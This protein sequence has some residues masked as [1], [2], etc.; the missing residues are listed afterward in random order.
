[1]ILVEIIINTT[2]Y[3]VS[4]EGNDPDYEWTYNWKPYVISFDSPQYQ[5]ARAWGGYCQL[6]FGSI[7]LSPDLFSSE[8]PPPVSNDITI[9]YTST[10][11]DSPETFFT[12]VAHLR[13][14]TQDSIIYDLFGEKYDID[15]L[16]E[17]TDYSGNTVPLPRAFGS[18]SYVNPVR[19]ADVG[20]KP[21]YHKGYVAGTKGTDWHVFDDG[22]DIDGNVTD[23]GDGTFSLSATPVGQVSISGT[24]KYGTGVNDE[25]TSIMEWA[26]GASYLNET[27]ADTYARASQPSVAHWAGNQRKILDFLSDLCAFFTHLFYIDSSGLHLVDM[28]LD[29]G[30]SIYT[31]FEYMPSAYEYAPPVSLFSSE[32]TEREPGEWVASGGGA[33][34]AAAVYVK[35]TVMSTSKTSSY[36][37]GSEEQIEPYQATESDITTALTDIESFIHKPGCNL[38]IPLAGSLPSPGEKL[39]WTD[40]SLGQSTDIWIRARTIKYNFNDEEII[41]EG[42]GEMVATP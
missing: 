7:E 3:R 1:M 40:T 34:T 5:L 31:E 4:M 35:E 2:T 21:T 8:W 37:Y 32:W 38:K 29:N 22:V 20:G 36:A 19:L 28:K 13:S 42:E 12:G 30:S 14:I 9:K 16:A 27:Y 6:G 18:V 41:I 11:D 15:L 24:G 17:D 39:S 33:P 23:N 26:C 25:L 10:N